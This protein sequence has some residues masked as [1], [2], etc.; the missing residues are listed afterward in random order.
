MEIEDVLRELQNEVYQTKGVYLFKDIER[1]GKNV[2]VT[3]PFHGNGQERNPSMGLLAEDKVGSTGVVEAGAANC[4]ACGAKH[5]LPQFVSRVLDMNDGG[6]YGAQWLLEKFNIHSQAVSV[7]EVFLYEYLEDI[8]LDAEKYFKPDL[9]FFQ[10]RGISVKTATEF[11]LGYNTEKDTAVIPVFDKFG[12]CR[13]FIQRGI[14]R[15]MFL[16]TAGATK[17]TLLFGIDKI[18]KFY[19]SVVELGEVWIVESAIDAMLLWQQ[20]IPALATMQAATS[21]HAIA[22]INKLPVSKIVIATD[23]DSAGH[24][25]VPEYMR[26][27][28]SKFT[29]YRPKFIFNT[30]DIGDLRGHQIDM[31]RHYM[32]ELKRYARPTNK[33]QGLG[34]EVYELF[35]IQE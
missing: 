16:N 20:G 19:D 12:V 2:M 21:E 7:G 15:K 1:V 8:K 11:R 34:Q 23:N 28:D 35:S 30:K 22:I 32:E 10:K 18:Y 33:V 6:E 13:M 26:L 29:L 31:E 5:N 9:P 4:L 17:D 14:S 24:K 25:A 3:C 27:L